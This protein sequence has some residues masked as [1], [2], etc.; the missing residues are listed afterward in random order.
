MKI[1]S[2]LVVIVIFFFIVLVSIALNNFIR[3]L[4]EPELSA[5]QEEPEVIYEEGEPVEYEFP[6][7]MDKG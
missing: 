4:I 3:G 6:E 1:K 5:P 2:I 7:Y